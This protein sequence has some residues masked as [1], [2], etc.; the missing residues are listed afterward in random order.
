MIFLRC[1][2]VWNLAFNLD[3]ILGLSPNNCGVPAL[4]TLLLATSTKTYNFLPFLYSNL[5]KR[6]K[7][8]HFDRPKRVLLH[9]Q[10]DSQ[11]AIS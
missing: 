6:I 5:Q 4:G 1:H 11:R 9:Q 2:L 8:T 10:R 3:M 7:I